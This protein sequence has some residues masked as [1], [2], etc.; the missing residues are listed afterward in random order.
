MKISNI[1]FSLANPHPRALDG[2]QKLGL[3]LAAL[4]MLILL[5]AFLDVSLPS[6]G[7]FL[8]AS[9]A[10]FLAGALV[11]AWR[12]YLSRPAGV[13]NDGIWFSTLTNGGL[14]GWMFGIFL[15]GFYILLYFF[16]AA[17]GLGAGGAA[18]SGLVAFFDPLSLLLK[19]QPASQWFVYGALYTLAILAMGGRFLFKYRHNRYQILRTL[20]VMFFQAGF[21]FFIPELME[22]LNS[23]LAA[24]W[25]DKDVKNMWP[26]D[27]DFFDKWHVDNMLNGGFIGLF[28]FVFGLLMI[29]VVSPFLTYR[30]GKRW[31]CSWVCGCGGLAETAG[32][33]FRQLSGKSLAAWRLERW[34][35]HLVLLLSVLMTA[36]VV[37]SYLGVNPEKY[38]ITRRSFTWIVAGLLIGLGLLMALLQRKFGGLRRDMVYIMAS[39]GVLIAAVVVM[40]HY[41]GEKH[42]LFIPAS[43]LKSFYGFYIGAIFS[44]VVGVGFYPLLGSRVWCR[45]GCPMAAILGIQQRLF[46]RFRI[47]TNGGQCISCGN[48]STYCEMGIDVRW[49]AQRGQ[50]IVRAS[51]VGCGIC[52][53]VCPRGVL[54]L[55]NSSADVQERTEAVRAIHIAEN[56]LPELRAGI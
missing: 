20:S 37:Y 11:F 43:G 2:A 16:P 35:I 19:G 8:A 47:T 39:L 23:D 4:A 46:S 12:T 29:F 50:D 54:R 5:L 24:R 25:F 7:V 9:L 14:W 3:G 45:F 40:N 56:R 44:G 52:S 53:A 27:Y 48:C 21:A 13:R 6:Q 28:M 22:G 51:C 15:T 10:L 26:L 32:D 38:Y 30:Y 55:E 49:Y 18:N 17:L 31:Y 1:S 42:I 36:A 34:M 41:S 33:P